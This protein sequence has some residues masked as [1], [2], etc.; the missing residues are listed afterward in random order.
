MAQ[1]DLN[2]YARNREVP[3]QN[4]TRKD[5]RDVS[6]V[7]FIGVEFALV[8]PYDLRP[9]NKRISTGVIQPGARAYYALE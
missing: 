9:L 1:G 4:L 7:M 5:P 6:R 8:F 2:C 3:H